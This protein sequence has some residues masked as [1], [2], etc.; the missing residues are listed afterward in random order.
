[1][2]S[3]E[4]KL[5]QAPA[6]ACT[7]FVEAVKAREAVIGVIGLGYV[8]LPLILGFHANG[9]RILGIDVD[10]AKIDSLEAGESYIRHIPAS[11]I[12]ALGEEGRFAATTDFARLGEADA[13]LIC[14]PTPLTRHLEPDMTYVESTARAMAP[15]LRPGQLIVLESTTYPGTTRDLMMPI[16][17]EGSGLTANRDFFVAYSPEREDPGNPEFEAQTIPK[18]VGA[19]APEALE[20]AS[21]LYATLVPKVVPVSSPEVAEAVKLTENIFRAV[22]IA[23]VN[24]LKVIYA[25][26][27]IDIW[28]VIDAAKTKPFGFMPFYPGPG[29][30]GHCIPIDPFYLTWKAREYGLSTRFIEL[31]GQI[32][33]NMP[34]HVVN[35]LRDALSERRQKA[36]KGARILISG[37]AYKKNVDD[38]RES[39]SLT[40]IDLIEERGGVVDYHDPFIP[41]IP[42]TREHAALAGRKSV[43][44]EAGTIAGYDAVLIATDHDDVDYRL[45]ADSAALVVDTRNACGRA[46]VS[47]TNIVKA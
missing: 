11:R 15:H 34:L 22:N 40:L 26:M 29:L 6:D 33:R 3:I 19:A 9:F 14:V 7:A 25:E 24:E 36:L 32:N 45:I 30:G 42:P 41:E 10:Q 1:M 18:V 16:L 5:R 38:M 17:E 12:A 27:G 39:P 23:M 13:V 2:S 8:G 44:L 47:G 20:M 37:I 43:P 31:A 35:T 4:Q 46:G 28:E 21:A